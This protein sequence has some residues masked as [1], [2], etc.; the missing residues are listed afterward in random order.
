MYIHQK[1]NWP[2]FIWD[3][4]RLLKLVGRVRNQQGRLLG[5]M[6]SLGFELKEEAVLETLT[7]DVIE[8]S[9]IEGELLNTDEVRS[10][11]ARRLGMSEYGLVTSSR[12]IE[13]VVEMMLDATQKFNDQLT[14]D[15]FFSWHSALFPSGRSGMT[16]ITI[17]DYRKD[18]TGPMQ[19]ISGAMGKE[20]VHFQAPQSRLV[21]E[22]MTRFI[23]WFNSDKDTDPVIC[24]AIA[25]LWFVTIHP[26]DD[27][28]GRMARAIADMQLARADQ[29]NQRFYS[30]SSQIEKDK[31]T[32]YKILEDTQKGSLDITNWIEWFLDCLLKALN[33]TEVNLSKV[34]VKAKFWDIHRDTVLNNRQH[35]MINKLLG[36]FFGKLSTS[37]YAKICKCSQDT[38]HRDIKDLITKNVMIQDHAGGRSTNYKLILPE[39]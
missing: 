5:K 15:R 25:H 35:D 13:G 17:G 1:P 16:K 38:A 24:A 22:E 39:L 4:N 27:G 37:K 28:N 3:S 33:S 12:D 8:S 19:V 2:D 10:S 18:D 26:M 30:M 23:Q 31:K 20:K 6:E 36:D 34:F 29:S 21:L 32:Y 11:V 9:K 14:H 7:T